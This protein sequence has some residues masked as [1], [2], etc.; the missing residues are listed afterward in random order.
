MISHSCAQSRKKNQGQGIHPRIPIILECAS[1]R[2]GICLVR[3][4]SQRSTHRGR[5]V[6][7][8]DDF[9]R[10]SLQWSYLIADSRITSFFEPW[11]RTILSRQ[12]WFGHPS[13]G[14]LALQEEGNFENGRWSIGWLWLSARNLLNLQ[15]NGSRNISKVTVSRTRLVKRESVETFEK[16]H[17]FFTLPNA[18]GGVLDVH[19][20]HCRL[21]NRANGNHGSSGNIPPILNQD[22]SE[23]QKRMRKPKYPLCASIFRWNHGIFH[24]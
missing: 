17:I 8:N 6:G 12:K 9:L 19:D 4:P 15:S 2:V 13:N 10:V 21:L 5:G 16:F 7:N 14:S 20:S 24:I 11:A 23:A 18:S 3:W 22:R 1:N